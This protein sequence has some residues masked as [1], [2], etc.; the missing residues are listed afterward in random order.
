MEGTVY[1]LCDP[2]TNLYKIGAT[3]GDVD[4]R[5]KKLQTGNSCNIHLVKKFD[6][7]A[8]FYVESGLHHQFKSKQ[9]IN[10]WY[11]LDLADIVDFEKACGKYQRIAEK[12]QGNP[13][14]NYKFKK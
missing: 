9:S 6:T 11:S 12:L 13:Y 14:F 7:L 5:I 10:E 8:P 2:S 1:L 4:K 3:R